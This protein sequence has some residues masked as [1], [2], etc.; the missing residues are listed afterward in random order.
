MMQQRKMSSLEG[1]VCR[2]TWQ[3]TFLDVVLLASAEAKYRP[4]QD[5]CTLSVTHDSF[6]RYLYKLERWQL[7]CQFPT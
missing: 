4:A 7:T 1:S 2:P 5:Q 6:A 3:L